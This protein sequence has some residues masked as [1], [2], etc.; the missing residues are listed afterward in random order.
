M[1]PDFYRHLPFALAV[2]LI[3]LAVLGVVGWMFRT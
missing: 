1:R 2:S 3:G